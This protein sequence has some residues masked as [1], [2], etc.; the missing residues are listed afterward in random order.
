MLFFFTW[1][2]AV[3]D[4]WMFAFGPWISEY[5]EMI[6]AGARD[7]WSLRQLTHVHTSISIDQSTVDSSEFCDLRVF[8]LS[9]VL[10]I[11]PVGHRTTVFKPLRFND[12]SFF[13]RLFFFGWASICFSHGSSLCF[14][15][16]WTIKWFFAPQLPWNNGCFWA[17][18]SPPPGQA[19]VL[20]LKKRWFPLQH[21]DLKRDPGREIFASE[22]WDWCKNSLV[23]PSKILKTVIRPS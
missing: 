19:H 10:S 18:S 3:Y 9:I 20:L 16:Q 6:A 15:D 12:L 7:F 17:C 22:G 11:K 23:A 8:C 21:D 14:N 5:K 4:L 1:F 13:D 2:I